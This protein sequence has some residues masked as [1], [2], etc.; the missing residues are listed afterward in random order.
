[1]TIYGMAHRG[2]PGKH[3]EN[4]LMSF[5]SA[6]DK[7]FAYLEIDVHLSKDGIPMVMHDETVDRMTD[8]SGRVADYTCEELQRLHLPGGERVPTLEEALLLAKGRIQVDIELKQAG[9]RHPGLE[10]AVLDVIRQHEL[11]DEVF[12]T[13]FDHYAIQRLRELSERIRLGIINSSVSP[14][15]FPWMKQYRVRYLSIGHP[16]ITDAF[17]RAC[18]REEVQLIAWTIDE[19]AVMRRYARDWP[20]VLVCTNE[21]DRWASV[22]GGGRG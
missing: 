12:I 13:S 9:D 6:I 17:V 8:G 21:L 22:Q 18:E 19:E 20:E 15:F 1:M 7:G 14:A 2:D 3:A 4:S 16:F 5:Q 10:Q 11:Y